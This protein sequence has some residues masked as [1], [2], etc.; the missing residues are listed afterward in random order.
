MRAFALTILRAAALAT[1]VAPA[2]ACDFSPPAPAA[3]AAPLELTG[4]VVDQA[5]ILPAD[6]G[7]ALD[8]R[9][10]AI[11]RDTRAQLVVVST[12]DLQGLAIEDYG[13]RLGRGWGI[14]DA[15]RHDGVLLI[16]APNERQV[17]IE[18][19]YGLEST[20]KSHRCAK[21]IA[22]DIL[23]KFRDGDLAGGTLAGAAAIENL[24]RRQAELSS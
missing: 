8:K 7:D 6:V 2:A 16:V 21:I 15:R 19:G 22:D 17:R 20:L 12:P 3:T 5:N 18:V 4:R 9:L 1:L 13:I 10:A 11:E 24:L 14:G 23:P